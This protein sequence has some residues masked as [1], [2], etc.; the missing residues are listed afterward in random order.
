MSE[1]EL[2]PSQIISST[3]IEIDFGNDGF[4]ILAELKMDG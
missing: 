3:N 1:D 4:K 2:K